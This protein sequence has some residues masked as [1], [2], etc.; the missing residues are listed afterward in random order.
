MQAAVKLQTAA[1]Q[2]QVSDKGVSILATGDQRDS[3][4]KQVKEGKRQAAQILDSLAALVDMVDPS[5]K[6]GKK[7]TKNKVSLLRDLTGLPS[8]SAHYA[9]SVEQVCDDLLE[10]ADK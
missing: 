6:L 7:V 5:I 9:G 10:M 2:A 1:N 4:E 3:Q 8:A